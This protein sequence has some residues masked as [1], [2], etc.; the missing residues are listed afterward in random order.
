MLDPRNRTLI[1]TGLPLLTPL[2]AHRGTANDLAGLAESSMSEELEKW[3]NVLYAFPQHFHSFFH[4][5]SN[6]RNVYTDIS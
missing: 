3:N 4:L 6:D 2:T 5:F 1:P